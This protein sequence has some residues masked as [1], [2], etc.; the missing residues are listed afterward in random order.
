MTLNAP[1]FVGKIRFYHN[2]AFSTRRPFNHFS[3]QYHNGSTWVKAPITGWADTAVQY[4][5]D[6]ASSPDAPGW[7]T[8]TFSPVLATQFRINA[9]DAWGTD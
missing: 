3:V 2:Q 5:T 4:N 9:T 7:R 1:R 8:V 6:E